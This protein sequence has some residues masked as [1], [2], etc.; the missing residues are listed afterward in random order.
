MYSREKIS[1]FKF[2]ARVIGKEL[3]KQKELYEK[4]DTVHFSKTIKY[5]DRLIRIAQLIEKDPQA[6]TDDK[7]MY[8]SEAS[9]LMETCDYL[10][11]YNRIHN[12]IVNLF[13]SLA[14]VVL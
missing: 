12:G 14:E 5:L 3:T 9:I 4:R 2:K 7:D 13:D 10:R 11:G 1:E 6:L 8:V